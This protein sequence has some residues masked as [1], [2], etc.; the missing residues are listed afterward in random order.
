MIAN[1][2]LALT[3]LDPG[4]LDQSFTNFLKTQQIFRDYNFEGSNLKQ[5]MRLLEYNTFLNAFYVNMD[6]VEGSLDTAQLKSSAISQ[7]KPLN[8]TPRSA[9]SASANVNVSFTA[10]VGTVILRK[11]QTFS[12]IVNNNLLVYS[13]PDNIIM[14]SPNGYFSANIAIFEGAYFADAYVFDHTDEEQRLV[15][16]NPNAD[17]TSVVVVVFEDG[18]QV[19]NNY[20]QATSLLG[21]D[22][23]SRVFFLQQAENEQ[24]E[25]EFGDGV[26]GRRPKDGARIVIDYRVTVGEDG[27]DATVFVPNFNPGNVA[28]TSNVQTITVAQGGAPSESIESIKYYAPRHFQVQERAISDPDFVDVLR[29]QFPEIISVN[30]FG[31]ENLN[32]PRFGKIAVAVDISGIDGLPDSKVQQYTDFLTPR[33]GLSRTPIFVPAD[34]SYLWVEAD[35]SY[36]INITTLT[37]GQIEAEAF[38]VIQDYGNTNLN[39][40]GAAVRGSRLFTAI[41]DA[42]ES[43]VS[44]DTKLYVY[45][46]VSPVP[47]ADA[48]NTLI[49]YKMP[50]LKA[51]PDPKDTFAPITNHSFWSSV[52]VLNNQNVNLVDDGQGNVNIVKMGTAGFE[53][54]AKAGTIDYDAGVVQLTNFK[55]DF[56]D[57][58]FIKL[59]VNTITHDIVAD[60]RT[61]LSLEDNAIKVTGVPKRL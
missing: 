2:S 37:Q 3:T 29:E 18:S 47:G 22:E 5:L 41:D 59:F 27:N 30:A 11:G 51:I 38:S 16:S 46:K 34:K 9:R 45:K 54:V 44:N 23:T 20:I 48:Q 60:Q 8:Y 43:I 61:V 24:Y 32:P 53:I 7:S 40:F 55:V 25:I 33:M 35:V 13:V 15:L 12:S 17:T 49:E 39:V 19:G 28:I 56:Y 42:D 31:G 36:N 21:L 14:T 58:T 6:M 52:Y 4:T 50:L 57:G 1:S 10:N 26:V